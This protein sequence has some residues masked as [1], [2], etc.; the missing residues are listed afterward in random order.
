AAQQR[1]GHERWRVE[2]PPVHELDH[3]EPDDERRRSDETGHEAAPEDGIA[4]CHVA[5]RA[6]GGSATAGRA[7]PALPC[8]GRI[9]ERESRPQGSVPCDAAARTGAMGP[10]RCVEYILESPTR[11]VGVRSKE[12]QAGTLSTTIRI[13]SRSR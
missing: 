10:V 2:R 9:P 5:S 3:E 6:R 7:G 1:V 11:R 8:A 4:H 13:M 12:G